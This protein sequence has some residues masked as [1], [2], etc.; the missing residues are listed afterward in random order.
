MNNRQ[1]F[2]AED[3]PVCGCK[4]E[5]ETWGGA[6]MSS[7]RWGHNFACCSDKCGLELAK[8]LQ[9]QEKAFK[10]EERYV[11]IKI[12]DM[13]SYQCAALDIQMQRMAIKTRKCVVVESDW[14]EYELVWKVIKDRVVKDKATGSHGDDGVIQQ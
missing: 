3:C 1:Y 12:K 9:A 11:V 10:R 2:L 6:R 14:P 8:R 4:D 7:S 13:D 5:P